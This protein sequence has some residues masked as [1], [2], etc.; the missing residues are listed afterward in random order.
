MKYKIFVLFLYKGKSTG[1]EIRS[2]CVLASALAECLIHKIL[3]PEPYTFII[4]RNRIIIP[5]PPMSFLFVM[6]IRME[7]KLHLV[8]WEML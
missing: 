7:K 5:T 1:L 6:T 3:I 4:C 8:N 2:H